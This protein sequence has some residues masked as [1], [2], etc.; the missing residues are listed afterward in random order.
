MINRVSDNDYYDYKKLNMPTAADT[1]S[2]GEKFSLDYQRADDKKED[3]EK[4]EK[5]SKEGT[6]KNLAGNR[7]RTVVQSGVKLELSGDGQEKAETGGGSAFSDL[8]QTV[9]SWLTMM[10]QSF[11]GLLDRIWNDPVPED[12]VLSA[13]EAP[14]EE[15]DRLSEEY[16]EMNSSGQ[17]NAM[18]A[19]TVEAVQSGSA[20]GSALE[21]AADADRTGNPADRADSM[22]RIGQLLSGRGAR[23]QEIQKYLRSGNLEQVIT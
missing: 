8:I 17:E 9:R 10:V 18:K 23:D 7:P 5:I 12:T 3:D 22:E 1:N 2:S 14:V 20:E 15:T 19:E 21:S 6:D 16:L 4:K 13:D 11:K